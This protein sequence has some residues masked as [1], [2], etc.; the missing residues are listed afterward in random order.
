MSTRRK[1]IRQKGCFGAFIIALLLILS[2][3]QLLVWIGGD[4][5]VPAATWTQELSPKASEIL[6]AA[7]KDID[8]PALV[9][10]HTHIA[11]VGADNSGCEVHSHMRTWT[12]PKAKMRFDVYLTASGVK[13]IEHADAEYV[14][15]LGGLLATSEHGGRYC[16]LAFDHAYFTDGTLDRDGSEFY[17]PNEYVWKIADTL[18][19]RA[20]PAM[21]VHPYRK[22][23]IQQLELWAG[24]GGRLVKWLPNSMGIDPASPACDAYYAKMVEL[25]LTLLSHTG[26]E[27]AV[28]ADERQA[29][30]NPLRLRRPLD[31][32]VRVIAAHCATLGVDIDLDMPADEQI[33][34]PSF[35][36]FMRMM[37]EPRYEGLLFGELSAVTQ[38]NRY[39]GPLRTLLERSD[40]HSRLVNGAD[41][42]LPAI[43]AVIHLDPLVDAGLLP[44]EEVAPLR[45]IFDSHPLVFDL[46]LKRRLR[47]P[48]SGIGFAPEAFLIPAEFGF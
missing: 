30:G 39:D 23:A 6:Q 20:L 12:N 44:A 1:T 45:E 13:D 42:P 7:F 17:V 28:E 32:G 48:E 34:R 14:A 29:L 10:V 4:G 5:Q 15:Q 24:R 26:E 38:L 31:Q 22:D 27:Q 9:D 46:V 8:T 33:L 40:L 25:D 11:G 36:L 16:L 3:P 18:G 47:H 19:D 43:N 35:K 2:Y 21:S 37:D 41:Y